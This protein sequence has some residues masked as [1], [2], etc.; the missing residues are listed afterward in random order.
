MH[1]YHDND[2]FTIKHGIFTIFFIIYQNYP[3]MMKNQ[4]YQLI[5]R[6]L[7]CNI[8]YSDKYVFYRTEIT[9]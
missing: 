5:P 4:N 7:N 9:N 2:A 6:V 1:H 3:Y 8:S